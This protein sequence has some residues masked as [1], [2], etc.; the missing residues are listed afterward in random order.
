MVE[1]AESGGPENGPGSK[2]APSVEVGGGRVR[3]RVDLK[4]G[5][6]TIVSW[7][8]LLKEANLSE[9]ARPGPSGSGP[10]LEAHGG[11]VSEPLP[12]PP[13]AAASHTKETAENEPKESQANRLSNVIERIERMYAGSSD[14]EDLVLDNMPDDDEYDTDDSFIDD[15]E[16]DDYFQVDKSAIKHDGFFV[17]RGKL[18]RIEPS[19]SMDQQPKKRRR[20]DLAQGGGS[21]D[22]H[23]LHKIMK[24]ENKG[25][26]AASSIPRSSTNQVYKEAISN[27]QKLGLD[28]PANPTEVSIKKTAI[29]QVAADSS[30]LQNGDAISQDMYKDRQKPGV[31]PSEKHLSKSK[32]SELSNTSTQRSNDKISH[33]ESLVQRKEGSSV[34]PKNTNLEKAFRELEKIVEQFRP[35]STDAQDPVNQSQ[36]GKKR[37]PP[38]IKLKLAKVARIAGSCYG[39]IPKDV[40]N[41]LMSI[42][43]HLMQITTLKRN[44]RAMANS[45]LSAKQEKDDQIQKMKQEVSEMVKSRTARMKSKE[46]CP[47]EREALKRK[48]NLD[49]VLENKICDLYDLYVERLEE[50]SGPPVRKLYE[51]LALLWPSGFM[52]TDGIK[53]AI[54]RA[55]DRKGLCSFRK[56]REKIK[57]K[58]VLASKAQ[59]ASNDIRAMNSHEKLLSRDRGSNLASNPVPGAARAPVVA[60]ANGPNPKQ[61]K[62]KNGPN[63]GSLK[64]EKT[65]KLISSSAPDHTDPKLSSLLPK[66]KVKRKPDAK[67]VEATLHLEKLVV[68]Q[69][70]ETA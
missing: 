12:P 69:G 34:R 40:I 37:L 53:R 45:G 16:L 60:S 39:R 64:Q 70:G 4:P 44:L 35:P 28:S 1:G 51:E 56:D 63:P 3:F 10:S 5:E 50:D 41:R 48:Y 18:E 55:K 6:T 38:E 9:T 17:N 15:T 33:E 7:K 67:V 21:G 23:S 22:G 32:E 27:V 25:K 30:G 62:T 47:E 14:E 59:D 54:Y 29:I 11:V 46:A 13:P 57:K 49:D 61:E 20:K 58:K 19:I 42:L 52:N 65:K 26:K 66:K 31:N 2:P 68:S 8:K 43:G 36:S 24:M